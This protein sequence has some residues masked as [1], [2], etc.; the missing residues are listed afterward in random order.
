[1]VTPNQE[2]PLNNPGG[3]CQEKHGMKLC[4][5]AA[6]TSAPQA[7]TGTESNTTSVLV[8]TQSLLPALSEKVW[9]GEIWQLGVRLS[10]EK[11]N[12]Y[13]L[14]SYRDG[15]LLFPPIPANQNVTLTVP[16]VLANM[17]VSDQSITVDLGSDPQPDT[18]IPL[19]ITIPIMGMSVHFSKATFVGDGVSS[20]RLILDADP[21]QTVN[22]ITPISVE[23]G[24]PDRVDDLYGVSMLDGSQDIFIELMRPNG[25]VTGIINIPLAKAIVTVQGPFEISFNLPEAASISPTP[26]IADP[27]TFS[28]APTAT[29]VALD[30]FRYSGISLEAGD[31]VYTVLNGE[32]TS[33]FR[34]SPVSQQSTLLAALPGAVAQI[35]IHPDRLGLDYLAGVQKIRDG[36]SYID[37][38]ALY[39]INFA[40]A[41]PRL[42]LSFEPNQANLVGTAVNGVWSSDGRY[43]IFRYQHSTPGD[44]NWK[45]LWLDMTCKEDA[46][47]S[48]KLCRPHE[49]QVR[50]DLALSEGSF[51]ADGKRILFSGSDNSVNGSPAL[52]ILNFNPPWGNND[53]ITNIPFNHSDLKLGYDLGSNW[54]PDGSIFT[55]CSDGMS[56]TLFCSIDPDTGNVLTSAI[57]TE[58]LLNY[59]LTSSGKQVLS[60]V[61]NHNAP[62]KGT[63]EIH[64]FDRKGAAGPKL[65]EGREFSNVSMSSSECYLAYVQEDANQLNLIDLTSGLT[66][67]VHTNVIPWAISWAGWV[68]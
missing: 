66:I 60:V 1:A 47:S 63:L 31:L 43:A 10:D 3:I 20:L 68:R 46:D 30:A 29:P 64:L 11:G 22:G 53:N 4:V 26:A 58:H 67:Q 48:G 65:A 24:K 23:I 12:V 62:G 27:N 6:T 32:N 14:S 42:L 50:P 16:A 25:K 34:Y 38:I 8:K 35:Y 51:S 18:V 41:A 37:N 44:A 36:Y 33:V 15:A 39:T 59:Q 55:Q 5:L 52:F 13:P 40:E 61:I 21:V 7:G 56:K 28:P 54:N 2:L 19:D 9:M 57:Y 49:I 17:D 45:F